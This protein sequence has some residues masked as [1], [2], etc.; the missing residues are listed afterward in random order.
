MS[1]DIQILNSICCWILQLRSGFP[2]QLV[3]G[4]VTNRFLNAVGPAFATL[5]PA[6][7]GFPQ[8]LSNFAIQLAS[9]ARQALERGFLNVYQNS[10]DANR[11]N[12]ITN[13][14]PPII[15]PAIEEAG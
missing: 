5:R 1:G 3:A 7:F 10:V 14:L 2:A 15:Q 11:V 6:Q 9:A 13:G 8:I 12:A 4:D